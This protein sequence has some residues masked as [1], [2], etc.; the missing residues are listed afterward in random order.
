MIDAKRVVFSYLNLKVAKD[1]TPEEAKK[2]VDKMPPGRFDK[3][4]KLLQPFAR[5]FKKSFNVRDAGVLDTLGKLSRAKGIPL[6]ELLAVASIMFGATV[7]SYADT[8]KEKAPIV[9]VKEK[10]P[11]S[12]VRADLEKVFELPKGLMTLVK[13][14]PQLAINLKGIDGFVE[15]VG[16]NLDKSI[17]PEVSVLLNQVPDNQWPE[18]L[19]GLVMQKIQ[20]DDKVDK[21]FKK[22]IKHHKTSPQNMKKEIAKVVSQEKSGIQKFVDKGMA[23]KGLAK[24]AHERGYLIS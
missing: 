18:L 1:M 4:K 10:R 5:L 3:I 22:F 15:T 11:I 13:V 24:K 21:K 6:V 7:P 20:E 2:I 8:A 9:Q 23:E 16:K 12:E 17:T 19:S 14:T